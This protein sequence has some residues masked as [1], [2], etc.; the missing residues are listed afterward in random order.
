MTTDNGAGAGALPVAGEGVSAA[1]ADAAAI[2]DRL[3]LAVRDGKRDVADR[4][5]AA[6][7]DVAGDAWRA[8]Y[9]A[10]ADRLDAAA[11]AEARAQELAA[12]HAGRV[13]ELPVV[14]DWHAEP[15]PREW[16]ARRWL[17]AAAVSLLTGPGG[18]GKSRLALQIAAS[19]AGGAGGGRFVLGEGREG[20]RIE[21][22]APAPV[23]IVGW[24]DDAAEISRRLRWIGAEPGELGDRLRYVPLAGLGPLWAPAGGSGHVST[25]GAPTAHG[26]A[27]AAVVRADRPAL[28]VLD[29]LAAAYGLSELDR[30]LVRAFLS[31]LAALAAESG[32][33]ILLVAHP[34]KAGAAGADADYSGSTDWRNGVRSLL[35]LETTDVREPSERKGQDAAPPRLARRL[36]LAKANYTR[37]GVVAW[38]QLVGE[39]DA[40]RPSAL[41]WA[42]AAHAKAAA[43]AHAEGWIAPPP[44][45][46]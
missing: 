9:L 1:E 3:R 37:E 23:L 19:V 43:A 38:L 13:L 10:L 20:P 29:P 33:A 44:R 25:S 46:L 30:S 21:G 12:W 34:P 45:A 31:W 7:A 28:V 22:A 14:A 41:R 18:A 17:P 8:E 11:D 4:L 6:E 40:E 26:E 16:L 5:L 36:R 27:L 39:G 42:E 35:V 2:A 15:P 32:A 24:E